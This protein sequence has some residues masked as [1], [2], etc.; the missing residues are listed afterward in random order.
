[1]AGVTFCLQSGFGGVIRKK[2]AQ[3]HGTLEGGGEHYT[4]GNREK[5]VREHE[6]RTRPTCV[7]AFCFSPGCSYHEV[8]LAV[9]DD[10]IAQGPS[11]MLRLEEVS[12]CVQMGI[13]LSLLPTSQGCCED[14]S[15]EWLESC[16]ENSESSPHWP[17]II[18]GLS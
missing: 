3:Q 18:A 5:G 6:R 4:R 15:R 9:T 8:H 11:K 14:Q 17:G 10:N 2:T 16:F 7:F 13:L 12:S 1:M